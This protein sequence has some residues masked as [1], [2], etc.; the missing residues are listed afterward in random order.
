MIFKW[1]WHPVLWKQNRHE[2]YLK[3]QDKKWLVFI[4]WV[5][6]NRELVFCNCSKKRELH[7]QSCAQLL[8]SLSW[9]A[10]HPLHIRVLLE[11]TSVVSTTSLVDQLYLWKEEV[12]QQF[13]FLPRDQA[14][15]WHSM[16][17]QNGSPPRRAYNSPKCFLSFHSQW[18]DTVCASWLWMVAQC[19]REITSNP[20]SW[21]QSFSQSQATMVGRGFHFLDSKCSSYASHSY[22]F[23]L[24]K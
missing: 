17:C 18:A 13:F 1:K 6:A 11:I 15:Y 4:L 2:E 7:S 24:S 20:L 8:H 22:F 14:V 3:L 21:F 10:R 12:R 9:F 16:N 5:T 23:I 19:G